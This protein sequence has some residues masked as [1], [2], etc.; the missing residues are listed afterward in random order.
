MSRLV[1]CVASAQESHD[2]THDAARDESRC[3]AASKREDMRRDRDQVREPVTRKQ[4]SGS[5][6]VGLH[7]SRL[8]LST[9][10]NFTLISHCL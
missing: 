2:V 7:Y 1:S 4:T 9:S 3:L 6:T 8:Y 10:P 5:L